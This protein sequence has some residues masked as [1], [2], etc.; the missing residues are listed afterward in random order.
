MFYENNQLKR[1]RDHLM[2]ILVEV[3]NIL[4]IEYSPYWWWP[5]K[6]LK[7]DKRNDRTTSC[8]CNDTWNLSLF[9]GQVW[10]QVEL[11]HTLL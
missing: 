7:L 1:V 6:L 10:A 3:I 11:L 2:V 8:I 5:E 4:S 9:S